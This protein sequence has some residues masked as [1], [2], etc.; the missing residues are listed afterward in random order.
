MNCILKISFLSASGFSKNFFSLGDTSL[1]KTK[2]LLWRRAAR[3]GRG[4]GGEKRGGEGEGEGERIVLPQ[5]N[6]FQ[7]VNFY[8][9]TKCNKSF[10]FFSFNR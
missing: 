2:L 1:H 8:T 4:G 5:A 10:P 3:K 9:S 7:F 6:F